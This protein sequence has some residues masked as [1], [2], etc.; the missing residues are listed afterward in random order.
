MRK[1]NMILATALVLAMAAPALHAQGRPGGVGGGPPAGVGGG[2]PGGL[3]GGMG[4]P[5]ADIG[6]GNGMGAGNAPGRPMGDSM[7]SGRA[8]SYREAAM[9]R[10]AEAQAR[11]AAAADNASEKGEFGK[12]TAERAR[13][14]KDADLET[15]QAF[16]A[17]QSAAARQKALEASAGASADAS[18][19][20]SSNSAFGK[21]TAARARALR[22]A[23]QETRRAFGA[24]QAAAA[25]AKALGSTVDVVTTSRTDAGKSAFGAETAA[26]ARLQKDA[27]VE[28]RQSFGKTQSAQAKAQRG[29]RSDSE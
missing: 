7:S 9:Q 2:P 15:R 24:L 22:D 8:T 28:L 29:D 4:G 3:G 17:Y 27:T 25:R 1:T 21:E 16:G 5:P 10:R 12:S 6:G 19:N 11:R 13:A 18:A 14:L 23:D 26:R 20:G